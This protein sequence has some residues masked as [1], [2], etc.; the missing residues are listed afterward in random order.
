MGEVTLS[1]QLR[2]LTGGQYVC[3]FLHVEI[4]M[5]WRP[6]FLQ[7]LW[8]ADQRFR[9]AFS[10]PYSSLLRLTEPNEYQELDKMRTLAG[11]GLS[12]LE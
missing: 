8:A 4:S 6:N 5:V 10:P 12:G 9:T 3:D 1:Y 11:V 2:I 7:V